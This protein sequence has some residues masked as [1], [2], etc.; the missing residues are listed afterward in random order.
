M[1]IEQLSYS[2]IGTVNSVQFE[3]APTRGT[4]SDTVF[5][6]PVVTKPDLRVAKIKVLVEV[7]ISLTF[8]EARR[9]THLYV[10]AQMNGI[11]R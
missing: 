2:K 9:P 10:Y 4:Y 3:T 8:P 7:T 1:Q 5:A 11:P 6:R